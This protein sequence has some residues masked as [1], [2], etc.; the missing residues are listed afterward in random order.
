MERGKNRDGGVGVVWIESMEDAGGMEG[1]GL[2]L[3]RRGWGGDG[4]DGE[5]GVGVEGVGR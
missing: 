1:M 4:R 3:G 5:S 2:G